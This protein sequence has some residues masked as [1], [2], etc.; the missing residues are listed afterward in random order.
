MVSRLEWGDTNT[1]DN[2][3]WIC[4]CAKLSKTGFGGRAWPDGCGWYIIRPTRRQGVDAVGDYLRDGSVGPSVPFLSRREIV[5]EG[6]ASGF[7]FRISFFRSVRMLQSVCAWSRVVVVVFQMCICVADLFFLT[8]NVDDG[9]PVISSVFIFRSDEKKDFAAL[10]QANCG[11]FVSLFSSPR[12]GIFWRAAG[13][14]ALRC[15]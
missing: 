12:G 3:A 8:V 10:E 13:L 7:G 6:G 15:M 2:G 5:R 14:L 9:F 1:D 11:C 4:A